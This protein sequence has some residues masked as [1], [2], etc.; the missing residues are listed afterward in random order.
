MFCDPFRVRG[1]QENSVRDVARAERDEGGKQTGA[2][3]GSFAVAGIWTFL[4]DGLAKVPAMWNFGFMQQYGSSGG[5]W[6][7]PMMIAVGFLI[8]PATIFVWFTSSF[9][10][11]DGVFGMVDMDSSILAAIPTH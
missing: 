3:A 5:L 11:Q 1:G 7:S 4:R 10:W 6:W 8:G 2:L 9:G